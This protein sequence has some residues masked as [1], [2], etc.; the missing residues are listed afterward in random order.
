MTLE[1]Q[2][3]LKSNP[4]YQK[5]IR[6]NSNWY[7]ILNRHPELFRKFES[8]VKEKYGLRPIDK[9]N[10]TVERIEL[11]TSFFQALK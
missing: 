9:L 7:K 3:K 8:E 4:N 6:E 1:V 2:F 5:Y 10:R 11:L